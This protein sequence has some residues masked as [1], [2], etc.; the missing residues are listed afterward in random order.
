METTDTP[1]PA[2]RNE[3]MIATNRHPHA[4]GIAL[5]LGNAEMNDLRVTLPRVSLIAGDQDPWGAHPSRPRTTATADG[6][7]TAPPATG[8]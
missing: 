6:P 1:R 3:A 5:L 8:T 2:F 4:A 7:I